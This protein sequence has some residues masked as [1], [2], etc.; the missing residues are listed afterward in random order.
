MGMFM[1][2]WMRFADDEAD[3]GQSAFCWGPRWDGEGSR[4]LV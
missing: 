1:K 3:G 4:V 2:G